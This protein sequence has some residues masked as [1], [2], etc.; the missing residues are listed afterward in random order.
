MNN[1]TEKDWDRI[2]VSLGKGKIKLYHGTSKEN[3]E[4][5]KQEGV[6]WGVRF[7]YHLDRAKHGRKPLHEIPKRFRMTYFSENIKSA[8]SHGEYGNGVVL[9]INYEPT[10]KKSI[11]YK[12]PNAYIIKVPIPL[13]QIIVHEKENFTDK[14]TEGN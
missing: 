3:W 6:L 8:W 2:L 9:E 5:I 12:T 11:D 14:P 1:Q 4:K 7:L 10:G 13:E